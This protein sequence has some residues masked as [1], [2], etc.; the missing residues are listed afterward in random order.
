LDLSGVGTNEEVW[1]SAYLTEEGWAFFRSREEAF[2]M[3]H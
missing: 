1:F 2:T 3:I